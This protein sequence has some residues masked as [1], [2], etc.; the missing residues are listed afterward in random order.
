LFRHIAAA[1]KVRPAASVTDDEVAD[2]DEAA[3]DDE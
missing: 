2:D 3:L 1:L